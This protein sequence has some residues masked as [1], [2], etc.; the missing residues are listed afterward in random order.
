[1]TKIDLGQTINTLAN[2]GVIAGIVFL[3]I[4]LRQ[5][6][7]LMGDEAERARAES[8]RQHWILLAENADLAEMMVKERGANQLSAVEEVRLAGYYMRDVIGYQTAFRQLP[9]EDLQAG[10]R[11]FR[12]MFH[13]SPSF[14]AAWED[15][16]DVLDPDFVQFMEL[17]VFHEP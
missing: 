4:E 11:Q 6:N 15:N 10:G 16:R 2:V 17:E 5:N 14:R 12:R 9:R 1:M 7:E 3:A 8:W 13:S